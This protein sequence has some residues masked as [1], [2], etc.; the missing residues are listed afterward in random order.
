[1]DRTAVGYSQD[2]EQ[3]ET[4]E[5]EELQEAAVVVQVDDFP[6]ASVQGTSAQ[7]Q[8]CQNP[9]CPFQSPHLGLWAVC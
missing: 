8:R 1:M 3:N 9:A 5:F 2:Y 6:A 7:A 4:V